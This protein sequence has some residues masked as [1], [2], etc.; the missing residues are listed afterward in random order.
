MDTSITPQRAVRVNVFIT[1]IAQEGCVSDKLG[2][3]GEFA[4][5]LIN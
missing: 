2:E 1:F 4:M 5:N 3:V